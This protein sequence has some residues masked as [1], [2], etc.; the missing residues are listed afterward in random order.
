MNRFGSAT[1]ILQTAGGSW[2]RLTAVLL[3]LL[4]GSASSGYAQSVTMTS[5]SNPI[6]DNTAATFNVTVTAPNA[7]NYGANIAPNNP[8]A[9]P[10]GGPRAGANAIPIGVG[11]GNIGDDQVYAL[12]AGNIYA[13]AGNFYFNYYGSMHNLSAEPLFIASNGFIR[14]SDGINNNVEVNNTGILA[15]ALAAA[16]QPNEAIYF[17]NTDL[18]PQAGEVIDWAVMNDGAGYIFVLTFE[19]VSQYNVNLA[20]PYEQVTV[21]L[22]LYEDGHGLTPN[23]IQIVVDDFP[24][25]AGPV[26]ANARNFTIGVENACAGP[27]A[28]PAAFT[29]GAGTNNAAWFNIDDNEYIFDPVIGAPIGYSF[30]LYNVGPNGVAEP[31]GTGDDVSVAGPLVSPVISV[32]TPTL[33][34]SMAAWQ[35]TFYGKAEYLNCTWRASVT[36][37]INVTVVPNANPVVASSALQGAVCSGQTVT[38]TPTNDR[39]GAPTNYTYAWTVLGG[40]P[41]VVPTSPAAVNTDVTWPVLTG[42]MGNAVAYTV[43][44]VETNPAPPGCAGAPNNLAVTVYPQPTGAVSGA[45]SVCASQ[46]LVPYTMT[47]SGGGAFASYQWSVVAGPASISGSS[48]GSSVN[49]NY[50]DFSTP[51]TQTVVLQC[52]VGNGPGGNTTLCSQAFTYNVT[53]NW[54]PA[55]KTV[56]RVEA[57]QP[58]VNE[59][60]N[61]TVPTSAFPSTYTWSISG[62]AGF[63]ATSPSVGVPVVNNTLNVTWSSAG[64]ATIGVIEN[65]PAGCSRTHTSFVETVNPL[66]TPVIVGPTTNVCGYV[67]TAAPYGTIPDPMQH[68]YAV[69]LPSGTSTYSW[70]N[71]GGGGTFVGSTTGTSAVVRWTNTIAARTLRVTE[72]NTITGCVGLTDL[73]VNVVYTAQAADFSLAGPGITTAVPCASSTVA[74]TGSTVGGAV[75]FTHD[76]QVLS[77]GT[78]SSIVA[79][80]VNVNWGAGPTGVIRHLVI[81]PGTNCTSFEDYTVTIQ[82]RPAGNIVGSNVVCGGTS[83]NYTFNLT[84]GGPITYAWSI[85]GGGA[86]VTSTSGAA[87]A[88][89]TVNYNNSANGTVTI[90]LI[91]T[92]PAPALCTQ[93]FTYNVTVNQ[94][95]AAPVAAGPTPVCA[96]STQTYSVTGGG[97]GIGNR[98]FTIS[99]V[100]GGVASVSTIGPIAGAGPHNFTITWN[101]AL[102]PGAAIAGSFQ[103]TETRSGCTGPTTTYNVTI[104]RRPQAPVLT[105]PSPLCA[106]SVMPVFVDVTNST[107][108]ITYTWASTGGMTT[109][110]VDVG[111]GGLNERLQIN[112]LGGAGAKSVTATATNAAGCQNTATVNFTVAPN[113]NPIISGPSAACNDLTNP[114]GKNGAVGPFTFT[115]EYTVVTPVAG[116][117]YSWTVTNGYVVG[118]GNGVINN[119]NNPVATTTPGP[120]L[121]GNRIRVVF[122]GPTPGAVKVSEIHPGGCATTTLDYL[123]VLSPIPAVQVLTPPTQQVCN[124]DNATVNLAASEAPFNYRVEKST[125]GGS[126]WTAISSVTNPPAVKAGGGALTWTIS[127]SELANNFSSAAP[128]PT[129]VVYDLRVT[130]QTIATFGGINCGWYPASNGVIVTVDPKASPLPP[131]VVT[132]PYTCEGDDIT[133]DVGNG[134]NPSQGWVVYELQRR[135]ITDANGIP[136]LGPWAPVGGAGTLIGNQGVLTLTDQSNPTGGNPLLSVDNYEYRVLA[137]TNIAVYPWLLPCPILLNAQPTA[138]VFALPVS[139]LVTFS[140]NPICWEQPLNVNLAGTQDG[141]VYEVLRSGVPTGVTVNGTGGAVNVQVPPTIVLASNPAVPTSITF[142]VEGRLRTGSAPYNRPIPPSACPFEFG[143]TPVVVNPKPVAGIS[144]TNPVCG[145]SSHDYSAVTPVWLDTYDWYLTNA[146][147][148]TVPATQALNSGPNTVNP[149]TVNW[150]VNLLPCNNSYNPI[151]VGMRLIQTNSFGCADTAD[152][153]ITVEPTVNDAEIQG[154]SQACIYGGFEN[155]LTTYSLVRTT[156]A[157]GYTYP[158]GTTFLWTAPTGV[159]AGVIRSGQNTPTVIIEWTATGGTNIGTLVCDVTLPMALGGCTTT[160][161]F[162]VIVYP[163]PVPAINGPVNVCQNQ[164]NV[165]YQADLY[166]NDTYQWTVVGGLVDHISATGSGTIAS[167]SVFTGVGSAGNVIQIDWLDLPNPNATIKLRQTSVAGCMNE[168]WHYVTVHPTP[169]PVVSGPSGV[170]VGDNNTFSTQ[171]NAPNNSYSWSILGPATIVSGANTSAAVISATNTGSITISVTETVL[172][173]NCAKT[174]SLLVT[175]YPKPTPVISRTAPAGGTLGGAC[176]GQVVTYTTP[177]SGNNYSWSVVNGTIAAGQGTNTINVEWTVLGTGSITLT[178]YVPG[179]GVQCSTVVTQNVE[180]AQPPAPS[181]NGP[182][183]VCGLSSHNYSTPAVAGNS[184]TWITGAGATITSGVNTNVATIQFG[185]PSAGSTLSVN[186]SVT[187][188]NILSGC[189]DTETITVTVRRQPVPVT[190][191]RDAPAGAAAQACENET[192]TYS[193][194][195]NLG[196]SYLWTVTGG[197]IVGTNTSNSVSVQWTAIGSQVLAVVETTTG[198]NCSQ[199]NTLNVSVTYQPVPAISGPTNVCTGDVATYSTPANPGSTYAWSILSGTGTFQSGTTSNSVTIEWTA[200][201]PAQL[202]VIETNGNCTGTGTVWVTVTQTPTST[203]ISRNSPAGNVGEACQGQLIDYSTPYNATSSYLWTVVGGTTTSSATMNSV[204]VQWN[205]VGNGSITVT[206]T[207]TGSN[208]SKTVSEN[209]TVVEQPTPTIAGPVAPCTGDIATY[210]VTPVAGHSYSWT[211]PGGGGSITSSSSASSITV[212]WL[213]GGTR[214]VRV[215]Q[216]APGGFCV[217]EQTI[218]VIVGVTPTAT[219]ISRISPTGSVSVACEKQ[220]IRYSTPASAT[221]TYLWSVIGGTFMTANTSSTVEVRWDVVGI[222]QISV[223]ETTVGTNCS[224]TATQSVNV[225]YQ[226]VPNISGPAIVCTGDMV[227]Y[228]TPNVPGSTYSWSLPLGGGTITSGT[229]SN[230]INVTWSTASTRSV[231]VVETNSNCVGETTL[232]VSVGQTPT[233][234]TITRVTANTLDLNKACEGETIRYTTPFNATSQYLWV[235]TGGNIVGSAANNSVDIQWNVAGVGSV[236]VTET[237]TGTNC[238]KTA[239]ISVSVTYKPTPNITGSRVACLNTI[240]SYSTPYV[241]GSTYNW[242]ISPTN[243]FAPIAGYPNASN[244]TLQW[245]QPGLHTITLTETSV[246]GGCFTTVTADVQVNPVPTPAITSTTGFG[247]PTS[248]RPGIVCENSQHTYTT[249]FTPGNVYNWIVNGGVILSGQST[250]TIVVRWSSISNGTIEVTEGV[251]GSN[252][253]TTVMESIII[254]RVPA[255]NITGPTSFCQNTTQTYSTPFDSYNSYQWTVTGPGT[256]ISGQGTNQ[257]SVSWAGPGSGTVAVTEWVTAVLPYQSCIGS[258]TRNITVNPNPATPIITGPNPVC[259]TNLSHTPQTINNAVYTSNIVSGV[260]YLWSVSSNGTIVGSSTSSSVTVRWTNNGSSATTGTITLRHTNVFGCSTSTSTTITINPLPNPQISGPTSVCQNSIQSYSTP[261][262]PGNSYVWTVSG[263]NI[264]RSGQNTPNITVEWTLP[265]NQSLTVVET[266]IATGCVAQNTISIFVNQLPNATITASGPT[267]FCQG[268]DVTLSAPMGYASYTWNTGETGRNIV[269]NRSGQYWVMITDANGCMNSSDTIQVN[270]FPSSM[271][272]VTSNGPLEFCEG[273]SVV[274]RGPDGFTQYLW[275]T[276]ATT[277]QITVTAAGTYSVIVADNN[278][279]SGESTPVVVTVYPKPRPTLTIVGSSSICSGDSVEIVAPAGYSNYTWYSTAGVQYGTGRSITVRSSDTVYVVVTDVYGCTG[280]SDTIGC[281]MSTV[282]QPTV[283][284]NGPLAFCEGNSVTLSAPAGYKSYYWSNGATTREIVVTQDGEYTVLVTNDM[285]CT[286]M[287]SKLLVIVNPL[288]SRPTIS[289]VGDTL[290]AMSN[291]AEAW[292]WYRNGTLIPGAG[293]SS[294]LVNI[295]GAYRVGIADGNEC[296]SLSQPFDVILTDVDDIVAGRGPELHVYP[297]P[298]NGQFTVSTEL[299]EAGSVRIELYNLM[300]ELV[301]QT[302]VNATG[303]NFRHSME[304]G[305]LA[306][307]IYNVVVATNTERWTVRLVRQ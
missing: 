279:C 22:L 30:R 255:P 202:Q 59:V 57:T 43:R 155:H 307:G 204:T 125:N 101:D 210:S 7:V 296:S 269:V 268:G 246:A 140:P 190:I 168:T 158:S 208:C 137:Q 78:I 1:A 90:Q 74:Y 121:N 41:A 251:P 51:I 146:P 195:S 14:F 94:T 186:I 173:T 252:C 283:T 19:G 281:T 198:T 216:T 160:R 249:P 103:V 248:R 40:P 27:K 242:A 295:S 91:A 193:I 77:G 287:S 217:G 258:Q 149:L 286:A 120:Q 28:Q 112:A 174:A 80:V 118:W 12:A 31:D 124:G 25:M 292:Q 288:P 221:S 231:R 224:K 114:S 199:T 29:Q 303:G 185:N 267:T 145:P 144:G 205:T 147:A 76:F 64:T 167:P 243:S 220:T 250:N 171:N 271:P 138:R 238:F 21:Q 89:F 247:S 196:S 293:G 213:A 115:Y 254:R 3:L 164:Q 93:T 24:D 237:T 44:M 170:C 98:T 169:T 194:P 133:V 71:P 128:P 230:S 175:A 135:Q 11:P 148:G 260:S 68:T 141:V 13:G 39:S 87:T 222:G 37:T 97:L 63:S 264:I 225:G 123:V 139:Q 233:T 257:I 132:T 154:P 239:T 4:I 108:G 253:V 273:G 38:Y 282:I 136:S 110:P 172:A 34:T 129:S 218:T 130:A 9:L 299:T 179:T 36:E 107:A 23:R 215:V 42:G 265:G 26:P 162:N 182:I 201:G 214:S 67:L 227:S 183:D 18:A 240:H 304:M 10:Y 291:V 256:I 156:C 206:E 100:I 187:E 54:R 142:S 305:N 17:L 8:I 290:K 289:R 49:I 46:T 73:T 82:P 235:A 58:C 95:P 92:G 72:T 212:Q 153:N 143:S 86:M 45:T 284:S 301:L 259:A 99:N 157:P 285:N 229:T 122:Y 209:V 81:N 50:T 75:G 197:T 106:G 163:L 15:Q 219:A 236:K 151:T 228:S 109:V 176:V 66:P 302:A 191:Q 56:T 272:V 96:N 223:T 244:I 241:A 207:T 70:S 116:N 300:G 102:E 35:R 298:T 165:I 184:Y 245:I 277:Q 85:T 113:P 65:T 111:G 203:A 126:T 234:T 150:G 47:S 83:H 134:P 84:G 62:S 88:T 263:G 177:A 297:N 105:N 178:E 226:P 180:V 261:G 232:S 119:F 266:I 60:R 280:A 127:A 262:I 52:V 306:Q 192:I 275:N 33:L 211:L 55:L 166:T 69:N 131:V 270:V 276:G 104:N 117:S 181:I 32:N 189:A 161:T 274:L 278:G 200:A 294:L 188:T 16:T 2:L 20:Y 61:Y 53:V 6:C 48:T 152:I 159:V 5:V 79:N